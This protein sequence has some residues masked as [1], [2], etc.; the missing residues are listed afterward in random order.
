MRRPLVIYDFG[1]DPCWI[2]LYRMKISL[3]FLSVYCLRGGVNSWKIFPRSCN[4]ACTLKNPCCGGW[5]ISVGRLLLINLLG[6][7]SIELEYVGDSIT[8]NVSV[9]YMARDVMVLM[10][11]QLLRWQQWEYVRNMGCSTMS[12]VTTHFWVFG[13]ALQIKKDSTFFGEFRADAVGIKDS[14]SRPQ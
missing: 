1:P 5:K 3:Y 7:H 6:R 11:L 9:V 4:W 10:S 13:N 8:I 12:Q 14:G 2:F